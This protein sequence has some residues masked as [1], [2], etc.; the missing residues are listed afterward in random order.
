MSKFNDFSRFKNN[1]LRSYFVKKEFETY[2][3]EKEKKKNSSKNPFS[4]S[5]FSALITAALWS[6]REMLVSEFLTNFFNS[7]NYWMKYLYFIFI[8][9]LVI[10]LYSIFYVSY[11]KFFQPMI[12]RVINFLQQRS[13]SKGVLDIEKF[14]TEEEKNNNYYL[15]KFKNEVVN[16]ISLS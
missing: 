13:N 7:D 12:D 9:M 10:L 15:K 3:K 11:F 1:E 6:S 8:V 4:A 5:I 2:L 16:Q 14:K